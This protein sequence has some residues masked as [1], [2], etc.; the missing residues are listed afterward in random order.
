MVTTTNKRKSNYLGNVF[1]TKK[2]LYISAMLSVAGM[3]ILR[4][5]LPNLITAACLS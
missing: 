4:A 3:L 5:K 2:A 1:S